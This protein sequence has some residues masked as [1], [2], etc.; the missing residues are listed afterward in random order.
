MSAFPDEAVRLTD[1]LTRRQELAKAATGG[2]WEPLAGGVVAPPYA[3][4][5][6]H[7][8]PENLA[9]YGG[10]LVGESMCSHNAAWVADA[11]AAL[12]AAVAALG[13]ILGIHRPVPV[14][15]MT[16]PAGQQYA[17]MCAG[18]ETTGRLWPCVTVQAIGRWLR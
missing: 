15:N 11:R 17:H 12:P 8:D 10:Q 2:P 4:N 6:C 5:P 18:C 14:I 16:A 7:D 3:Q 13:E 9:G 1:W